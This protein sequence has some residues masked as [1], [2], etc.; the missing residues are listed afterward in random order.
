MTLLHVASPFA[1]SRVSFDLDARNDRSPP[2]RLVTAI[3]ALPNQGSDWSGIRRLITT[4]RLAGV[5]ERRP[6]R[7]ERCRVE[8]RGKEHLRGSLIRGS[9]PGFDVLFSCSHHLPG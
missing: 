3:L 9:A 8:A 7:K 1:M 5:L 2:T 6:G 4:V